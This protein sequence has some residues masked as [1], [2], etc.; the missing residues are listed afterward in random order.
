MIK[1]IVTLLKTCLYGEGAAGAYILF[2]AIYVFITLMA[3]YSPGQTELLVVPGVIIFGLG[4]IA[5]VVMPGQMR[6][7]QTRKTISLFP[8]LKLLLLLSGFTVCLLSSIFMLPYFYVVGLRSITSLIG[9]AIALLWVY[10]LILMLGVLLAKYISPAFTFLLVLL[11]VPLPVIVD[12]RL[13]DGAHWWLAIAALPPVWLTF[14]WFWLRKKNQEPLDNG[15]NWVTRVNQV[16]TALTHSSSFATADGTFLLGK[17]DSLQAMARRSLI[18]IA[19]TCGVWI[20]PGVIVY[21][22]SASKATDIFHSEVILYL[23]FF[24]QFFYLEMARTRTRLKPVWLLCAGDRQA[25]FQARRQQLL[26]FA[27]IHYGFSLVLI[28]CLPASHLLFTSAAHASVLLVIVFYI[29]LHLVAFRWLKP[30]HQSFAPLA[31]LGLT[32]GKQLLVISPAGSFE[33][34]QSYIEPVLVI[35]LPLVF[36]VLCLLKNGDVNKFDFCDRSFFPNSCGSRQ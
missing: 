26:R 21:A 3:S 34:S 31:A 14:G 5:V 13:F 24:P 6:A 36:V 28:A 15:R 11:L 10:S 22:I 33:F 1:H 17:A 18:F 4:A 25:L 27:C 9:I 12:M 29:A 7:L 30:W 19:L 16:Y 32:F 23:V 35:G 8:G 20:F 2:F